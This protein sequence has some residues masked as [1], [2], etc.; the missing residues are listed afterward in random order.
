MGKHL[1]IQYS[2][3]GVTLHLTG[4]NADRLNEVA[5]TCRTQGATVRT[6]IG[7][8]TAPG[9]QSDI[10]AF[11][12]A[13]PID[14]LIAN[15]GTTSFD[16]TMKDKPWE[17]QYTRIIETNIFGELHT[18][19]PIL[20]EMR[21]RKSGQIAIMSSINSFFGQTYMP[22][23][24]MTKAATRSF[25]RD[26]RALMRPE[27]I[28]VSTICPGFVQSG[29][30]ALMKNEAGAT[31]PGALFYSEER[32][33]AAIKHGLERDHAFIGFPAIELFQA[34]F[35]EALPPAYHDAFAVGYGAQESSGKRWT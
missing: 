35:M 29:M 17:E 32:A 15:A 16:P 8:I 21:K 12:A 14:L 34:Y 9:F 18:I 19:V 10:I 20:K 25:G 4:Q 11:D 30:T 5:N 23:Y 33:A 7:D 1:A 27:G 28:H 3:P 31:F 24:N 26:L 6:Y 2:K 13:H 22:W